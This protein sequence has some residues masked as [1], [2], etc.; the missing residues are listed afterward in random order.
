V[1]T[2]QLT[3]FGYGLLMGLA[4]AVFMT[5]SAWQRRRGIE[6]ELRRLHSHLHDHMAI[7]QEGAKQI[8]TEL[9]QL[10]L[11]NENLRVTLQSWKQKPDRRELHM[12][13]VYDDAVRRVVTTVPGFSAYW[14]NALREAEETLSRAD[15]GLVAFA[16]RI[17]PR[18]RKPRETP[19]EDE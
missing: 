14:E 11:E 18:A 5:I 8:K 4:V 13:L 15:R 12:L 3:A 6:Q 7:T 2:S 9:E 16:R 10:R 1:D 19:P 17:L